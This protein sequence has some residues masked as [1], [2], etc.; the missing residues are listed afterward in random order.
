MFSLSLSPDTRLVYACRS[1]EE[2]AH[3]VLAVNAAQQPKTREA[4]TVLNL[5]AYLYCGFGVVRVNGENEEE[6]VGK[7]VV[8]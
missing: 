3:W 4:F 7:F 1:E 2:R 5:F 8:C 6:R